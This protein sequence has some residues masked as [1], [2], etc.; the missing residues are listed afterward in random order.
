MGQM[1]KLH[2]EMEQV[3]PAFSEL[4]LELAKPTDTGPELEPCADMKYRAKVDL[5][6]NCKRPSPSQSARTDKTQPEL[7]GRSE[8]S[9]LE[10]PDFLTYH[11]TQH[12]Y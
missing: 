6:R 4:R 7:C 5:E 2:S 10:L 1:A 3:P 8:N 9:A 12:E 11:L